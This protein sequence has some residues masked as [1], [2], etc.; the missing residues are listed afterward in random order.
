MDEQGG[1]TGGYGGAGAMRQPM[2]PP[3]GQT[4]AGAMPQNIQHTQRTAR[5][6]AYEHMQ[7]R[8]NALMPKVKTMMTALQMHDAARDWRPGEREQLIAELQPAAEE[9]HQLGGTAQQP[10]GAIEEQKGRVLRDTH[11]GYPGAQG[12]YPPMQGAA[13]DFLGN[14][15]GTERHIGGAQLLRQRFP[16][17]QVPRQSNARPQAPRFKPQ[18]NWSQGGGYNPY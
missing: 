9:L 15:A 11:L 2:G 10:E 5:M 13:I 1:A 17:E 8:K 6:S 18:R 3:I 7:A 14:E 12:E 16:S 4:G